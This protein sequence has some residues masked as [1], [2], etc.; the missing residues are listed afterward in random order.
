MSQL[1]EDGLPIPWMSSVYT[2][3]M[4]EERIQQLQDPDFGKKT[5]EIKNWSFGVSDGCCD[6]RME[7]EDALKFWQKC[8]VDRK[9]AIAQIAKN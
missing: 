2:I 1:D 4:I 3:K 5:Q 9:T 7:K 6:H 8:L